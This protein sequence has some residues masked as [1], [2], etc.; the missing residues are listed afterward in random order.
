M[1]KKFF[2][3]V[4]IILLVSIF[5]GCFDNNDDEIDSRIIGDWIDDEGIIY[6]YMQNGSMVVITDNETFTEKYKTIN[7]SKIGLIDIETDKVIAEVKYRVLDNDL[8]EIYDDDSSTFM[9]R[10]ENT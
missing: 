6:K 1:N 8:I 9:Y 3:I 10:I 7:N 2:M 4:I 5:N